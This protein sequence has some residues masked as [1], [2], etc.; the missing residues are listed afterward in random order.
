MEGGG[1]GGAGTAECCR[2]YMIGYG[3]RFHFNVLSDS[4][5][6]NNN[7]NNNDID[8]NDIADAGDD[9]YK[10]IDYYLILYQFQ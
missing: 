5:N 9:Q 4:N 6:D 3:F 10:V 7:D 8:N 1:G 2:P